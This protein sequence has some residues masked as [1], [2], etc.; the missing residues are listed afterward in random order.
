MSGQASA[1]LVTVV[2]SALVGSILANSLLVLGVALLAPAALTALCKSDLFPGPAEN[3]AAWGWPEPTLIVLDYAA[4]K[5]RLLREWLIELSRHHTAPSHP[6][7][8]LLLERH[9]NPATGWWSELMK[10]GSASEQG[11]GSLFDEAGAFPVRS[12]ARWGYRSTNTRK[13]KAWS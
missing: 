9:A 12:P 10:P 6:L 5:S 13:L 2:Q 7:R 4:A 1:G 8:I 11:L 3:P